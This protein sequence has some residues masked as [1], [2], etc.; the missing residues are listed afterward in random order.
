MARRPRASTPGDGP[1]AASGPAFSPWAPRSGDGEPTPRPTPSPP[2]AGPASPKNEIRAPRTLGAPIPSTPPSAP[3]GRA[4]VADERRAPGSGSQPP[5][6]W[7]APTLDLTSD[8][9]SSRRGRS[10]AL[11]GFAAFLIGAMV[12]G[13]AF[14][15][16]AL[17]VRSGDEPSTATAETAPPRR[18][19]PAPDLDIRRILE[20]AQPSVVSI[21]TG[22]SDS[23]FGGAGSGVVISEDGLILTNAHVVASSGGTISVRFNDGV[24]AP[25]TLIGASSSDDIALLQADRTGLT[26][27]TL[28]SS[29]NLVVGDPVVAIGNALA[30]GGDP[31]VTSGIVSAKDRSISDGTISL[32][33]LIQTDAAINPG[34]SGGPLVNAD[35]EVVG[36]NT[37]IIDG[38]QSVG[39]ALAIDQVEELLDELK[40]GGGDIQP[41]Q[42]ILGVASATIDESLAQEIRD[43]LG[44]TAESGALIT[45]VE[46][47]SAASDA[48]LEVG[49]VIVEADGQP[50]TRNE[51]V[52]DVIDTKEPGDQITI[53]VERDGRRRSF[54]VTL[55]PK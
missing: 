41:N 16:Y 26:P 28:G 49:D 4:P 2:T 27:A 37:A 14:A 52:S 47:D 30:L 43:D 20:F 8:A 54:D 50:V 35:G 44:V 29:A 3:P 15:T 40:A 33:N 38:A 48:G 55:G 22:S 53:T 12:M 7:P 10:P 6:G 11:V 46:P 45:A 42:A 5:V 24:A 39:F 13:G 31:S 9:D 36:I 18:S 21:T 32:D 34:N 51:D 17:G 19:G 23:I 1:P 25:A